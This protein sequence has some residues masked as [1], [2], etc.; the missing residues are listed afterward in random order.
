M[1]R[2]FIRRTLFL[3]LVLFGVATLTFLLSFVVP[4]DPV[5]AIAGERADSATLESIVASAPVDS[6]TSIMSMERLGKI[7]VVRSACDRA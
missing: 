4:S 7:F 1:T 5:R 3:A 2:Y 6:P